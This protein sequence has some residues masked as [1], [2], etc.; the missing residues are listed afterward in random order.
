MEVAVETTSGLERRMSVQ[1]PE[2]QI[3]TQVAERLRDLTRSA[4]LPGFRPGKVPLKVV[5]RRFGKQVR[6]EVVGELLQSSFQDALTQENLRPA[7]G[8]VIDPLNADEGAGLSYTAVFEVYPT[9]DVSAAEGLEI[10]RPVAEVADEDVDNMIDTLRKQRQ[11]WNEVERASADGDRA[12]IDFVGTIDGEEFEGGKA[13]DIPLELG[14]GAFIPGFEEG[15]VG[16]SAGEQKTIDVAFPEDYGA[17]HLAG[18]AAQ[19]AITLNKVEEPSLPEIDEE[20]VKS[21]GVEDGTEEALRTEVGNNMRREL[22]DGLRRLTKQRV[23]DAL[24]AS[25]QVELPGALVTDEQ[26]ALFESQANQIRQ[27]GGDPAQFGMTPD[28]FED[29]ARRRVGLG[30][31]LAEIVKTN[32]LTPDADKVREVVESMASTFEEPQQV[33]AYYYSDR[34]RLAEIESSVL[35]DQVVD[36]LIEQANVTDEATSFEAVMNPGQEAS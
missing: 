33:V 10:A 9:L 23:M 2:E 4:S 25:N 26:Q 7:G 29:D 18:K 11:E 16:M 31:L 35:E 5:T 15:V 20:F 14:Q 13:E 21:Y 34:S 30:L 1:L 17:E 3:A 28:M 36:M 19:F 12:M 8:P 22:T 24:L 32:G 6:Q 27:R